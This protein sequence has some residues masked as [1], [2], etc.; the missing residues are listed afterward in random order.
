M[1]CLYNLV[2]ACKFCNSSLKRDIAFAFSDIHPYRNNAD[3]YYK[4]CY[5]FLTIEYKKKDRQMA[6]KQYPNNYECFVAYL[7]RD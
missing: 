3:A 6:R 4:K 7:I 1:E 2:P 5:G